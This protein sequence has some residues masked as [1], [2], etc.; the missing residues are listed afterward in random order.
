VPVFDFLTPSGSDFTFV[1]DGV[2]R[3]PETSPTDVRGART[4]NLLRCV[5]IRKFSPLQLTA[6][7]VI[8][9]AIAVNSIFR[10]AYQMKNP[11]VSLIAICKLVRVS[12][13]VSGS[14]DDWRVFAVNCKF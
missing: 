13:R 5:A 2:S 8:L 14:L 1:P 10:D 4:A 11:T 12:V 7:A 9:S 6:L 3:V